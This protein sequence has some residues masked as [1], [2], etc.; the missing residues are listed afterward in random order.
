MTSLLAL[1]LENHSSPTIAGKK[2][3]AAPFSETLI[4]RGLLLL[5]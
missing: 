2:I 4:I 5:T 3:L 1:L